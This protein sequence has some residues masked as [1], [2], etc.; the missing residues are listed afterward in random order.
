[1]R[2]G[3]HASH[4][5]FTPS[6]LL[7]LVQ[8]AE[9]AGF[10]AVLSSDHFHPWSDEQGES[11]FAWSWLGAAMQATKLDF[12]IVNAPGQRY[13]PAI[14]AQA[15]ATLEEMFPGRFWLCSGSG[16]ALNENI[17]GDKWPPKHQR[18]ARLKE[19]V[20]L[21]RE[22]WKGEYVSH[23]GLIRVEKARLYTLPKEL[24]SVFG[25]AMTEKTAQWLGE[26]ADGMITVSKPPEELE[27]MVSAFQER[28]GKNKPLVL[29]VQLSYDPSPEKAL[30]LAWEQ[31]R[32]NIF[33]SKLLGEL[34]TPDQ[35]DD[36]GTMVRPEDLKEHVLVG[37]QTDDFL[38]Q[39]IAYESLGFETVILHNV[40]ENQEAFIDF[41][42][43]ELLPAF[44][45]AKN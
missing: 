19:S 43:K 27:K 29:K 35:F 7:K 41:F 18:N 34:H 37:S 22:L 2:I 20:E 10:E 32:N 40:N 36:L 31:W 25:A 45:S 28:A 38:E 44:K 26:W 6:H 23:K 30:N 13:H 8:K 21:M 4:E 16:Q 24:P 11:G 1:M 39:L 9:Q 5:Q 15:V 33:P 17:T 12:G 3:Y 14:I 42:E